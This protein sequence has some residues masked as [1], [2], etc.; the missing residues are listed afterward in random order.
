MDLYAYTQIEN[1]EQIMKDNGIEV[2]RLRGLRLM[3]D[4]EV[5]S[6]QTIQEMITD[7]EIYACDSLCDDSWYPRNEYYRKR[8]LAK[9]S[10]GNTII[11][12]ENIHGKKRKNL[13]FDIKKRKCAIL[14]Q[15]NMW[16]KYAGRENVLH[17][18]SRIG[19]NNWNYF[20]GW[21]L[22]NKPWFLEKV[23]DSFDN[24]YCDIYARIK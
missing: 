17:I 6:E 14:Q 24:T 23:D 22:E 5:I 7:A 15:Y 3:K 21:Q 1:L 16:N 20:K 18:H 8:Y 11:R 4:E 9:N 10:D 19:G 13:K 12:W 2:P